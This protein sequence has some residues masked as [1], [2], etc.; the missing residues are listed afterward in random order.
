[1]FRLKNKTQYEFEEM[2][3]FDDEHRNTEEVSELNVTCILVENGM[4]LRELEKGLEI[5]AS[6]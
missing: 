3:F 2:L 5:F 4:N 6:K 1:L